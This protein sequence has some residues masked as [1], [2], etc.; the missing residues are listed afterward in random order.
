MSGDERGR[1][2]RRRDGDPGGGNG[3]QC[4]PRH[5]AP[6]ADGG[7]ADPGSRVRRSTPWLETLARHAE[8]GQ[9]ALVMNLAGVG[10]FVVLAIIVWGL[11][12]V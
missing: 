6:G 12:Q 7:S 5:L 3:G 10:L 8:V 9:T 2:R 11:M 4:G 1:H